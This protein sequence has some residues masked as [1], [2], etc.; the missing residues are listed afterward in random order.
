MTIEI[1]QAGY[2]FPQRLKAA[3]KLRG[4]SQFQLSL[5]ANVSKSA[6]S[7]FENGRREPSLKS[8]RSLIIALRVTPEY[9][10]GMSDTMLS[11]SEYLQSEYTSSGGDLKI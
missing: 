3:R 6:L 10:L 7:F 2:N 4:L 9:L 5:M 8:F 1:S 11:L